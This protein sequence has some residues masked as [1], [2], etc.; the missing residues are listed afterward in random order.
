M[1]SHRHL[2]CFYPS[3]RKRK[4]SSAPLLLS[5]APWTRGEHE[6]S[7]ITS[8]AA[9]GAFVFPHAA[10]PPAGSWAPPDIDLG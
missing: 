8:G 9:P 5:W 1:A 3:S 6:R 7:T 4:G 10:A 2:I